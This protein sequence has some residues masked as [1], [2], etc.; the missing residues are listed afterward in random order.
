MSGD[1]VGEDKGKIIGQTM[2]VWAG[3]I[4]PIKDKKELYFIEKGIGQPIIL[5]HGTLSDFREWKFRLI[6]LHKIIVSFH[7]AD[8]MLIQ[9]NGLVNW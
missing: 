3:E 4:I 6:N 7:I 2:L 8:G 9:T 5:I 1:Q